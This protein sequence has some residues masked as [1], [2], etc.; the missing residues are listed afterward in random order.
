MNP[1]PAPNRPW[2]VLVSR[3]RGVT[4]PYSPAEFKSL[5]RDILSRPPFEHLPAGF[6]EVSVLFCG[7]AEIRRLNRDYR[8]KDRPT[9]VLSFPQEEQWDRGMRSPS[10]GD[11]V[12]SMETAKRQARRF[13]TTFRREIFRLTAH[14]LLHLAGYDH[15]KVPASKAQRMRRAERGIMRAISVR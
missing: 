6:S 3:R 9:D 1:A 12:I 7:D 13:G 8:R 11:L 15:E 2:K 10:L 4:S 14:G 5:V